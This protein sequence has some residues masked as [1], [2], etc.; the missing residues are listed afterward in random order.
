MTIGILEKPEQQC[1]SPDLCGQRDR[2][3]LDQPNLD[4]PAGASAA[5]G[6]RDELV[7]K[8]YLNHATALEAYVTALLEGDRHTAADVVQ[9]TVLRAWRHADRLDE[10]SASFRP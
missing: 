10:G 3:S 7:R 1:D 8:L 5:P 2:Q 4:Q 6:H 9:E